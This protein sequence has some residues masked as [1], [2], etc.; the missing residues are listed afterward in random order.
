MKNSKTQFHIKLNNKG[1]AIITVIVSMLFILALGAALLYAAYGG[2]LLKTTERGDKENFYS[3]SAAMDDIRLGIQTVVTEAIA[4]AYTDVLENF[5]NQADDYNPQTDFNSRFVE[6][7]K[8][9]KTTGDT[10]L[11]EGDKYS[12]SALQGFVNAPAGASATVSGGGELLSDTDAISFKDVSVKYVF[13]GYETN[14]TTDITVKMPDFF[15]GSTITSGINS[16]SIVANHALNQSSGGTSSVSGTVFVGDGGINV[17]NKGNRLIFKDGNLICKGAVS[18]VQETAFEFDAPTGELWAGK[19]SVG[20][21]DSKGSVILN[22]KT[23]VQDDL[24]LNGKGSDATLSGTYFGFGSSNTDPQKSSSILINGRETVLD[25]S[26]LSKLFLAGVGFIDTTSQYRPIGPTDPPII[27][28]ESLSVI[29]DQLAYLV[30]EECITNYASNPYVFDRAADFKEPKIEDS[31]ALWDEKTLGDYIGG[32]KGEIKTVRKSIEG[33]DGPMLSYVFMVFSEKKYANEYFKDY[34]AANP[35]KITQYLDLYL[36]LTSSDSTALST[37]GSTYAKIDEVWALKAAEENTLSVGTAARFDGMRS[38]YGSFV[39]VSELNKLPENTTL[40]FTLEGKA[41][42]IVTTAPGFNYSVLNG[43]NKDVRLII[44]SGNVTVSSDFK[45]III[46]GGTVN[47]AANVTAAP[48]NSGILNAEAATS[49]GAS[50]ALSRFIG[51]GAPLNVTT[52]E[53]DAWDLDSLV[54]YENWSKH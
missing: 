38:P 4:T 44:A 2:M 39:N 49:G 26:R 21:K 46:A 10:L 6:T 54:I 27:T 16:Y 8:K 50:Y 19:F 25:I 12:V 48:L 47:V 29:S 17:G 33:G 13:E 20:D 15:A 18:V 34:F 11:F 28:G 43:S 9:S 7:L 40:T 35:E 37:A 5:T 1:S 42:A 45:G 52:T 32:E 24:V 51:N 22:G 36:K 31:V 41:V 53:K 23:Y 3:A 30:P 14:I